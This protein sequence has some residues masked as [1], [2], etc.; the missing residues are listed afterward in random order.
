MTDSDDYKGKK[1]MTE[2]KAF[3]KTRSFL[4]VG[5]FAQ[6]VR[7]RLPVL[8]VTGAKPGPLLLI[9]AAQHGR[10]LNGVASIAQAFEDIVPEQ[11]SGSVVFLPVMNPLGVR[12]RS[13]DYPTEQAR[14]RSTET[15]QNFNLNR[16]WGLAPDD[17]Y[18]SA[19]TETVYE[20]YLKHADAMIDFHGWTN[21]SVSLGMCLEKD[22]EFMRAFGVPWYLLYPDN[23]QCTSGTTS[24]VA[25]KLGI[26]QATVE[27]AS[28]NRVY[29][30]LIK[31]GYTG[32]FNLMKHLSMLKGKPVLPPVQHEMEEKRRKTLF[33]ARQE[34]LVVPEKPYGQL[35]K[36][37]E[38]V[39]RLLSLETLETVQ[40]FKPEFDGLLYH[41]G[42]T[43]FGENTVATSLLHQGQ[44]VGCVEEIRKT[45]RNRS[46]D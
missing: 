44:F 29:P 28:Q 11:V 1:I 43:N 14:F 22:Q 4:E 5:R 41:I 24:D 7:C 39:A 13:Q 20:K 9:T 42:G 33:T 25:M 6:G 26:P 36:K 27:L 37:G 21:F 35:V 15:T 3:E 46:R 45:H 8:T 23:R 32:I 2:K 19:T 38:T 40:E 10:E 18:V 34:G 31:I 16:A 12:M 30:E 17:S